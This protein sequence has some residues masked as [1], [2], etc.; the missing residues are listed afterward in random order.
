MSHDAPEDEPARGSMTASAP[1]QQDAQY[2]AGPVVGPL[3]RAR[4]PRERTWYERIPIPILV[5][6]FLATALFAWVSVRGLAATDSPGALPL[7]QLGAQG[8]SGNAGDAQS[9]AT[10][11]PL[12]T[13]TQASAPTAIPAVVATPTPAAPPAPTTVIVTFSCARVQAVPD[14]PGWYTGH[15]CVQAPGGSWVYIAVYY[16]GLGSSADAVDIHMPDSGSYDTRW[17]GHPLCANP[18]PVELRVSGNDPQGDQLVGSATV[19][20]T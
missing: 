17:N 13:V 2:T 5:V 15:V 1:D 19:Q 7:T 10:D 6:V 14:N 9:V 11:S 20:V 3:T 12:P 18:G 16:C 8:H 4:L